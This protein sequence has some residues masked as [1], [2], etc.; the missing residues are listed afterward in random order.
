MDKKVAYYSRSTMRGFKRKV[1]D[2]G[3]I[4]KVK[5]ADE[6]QKAKKAKRAKMNAA[7]TVEARAPNC[8]TCFT[9]MER[10]SMGEWACPTPEAHW[11]VKE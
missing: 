9:Q 10:N 4:E 5:A 11:H 1:K 2:D 8:P 6:R 3:N 7:V